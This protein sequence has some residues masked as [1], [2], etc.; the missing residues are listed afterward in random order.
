L[1]FK[2]CRSTHME[3]NKFGSAFFLFFCDFIRFS[4]IWSKHTKGEESIYE[5]VPRKFWIYTEIPS[6]FTARP[7]GIR[8]LTRVPSTT[9]ASSPAA[10]GGRRWATCGT[11]MRLSSPGVDSWRRRDRRGLRRVVSARSQWSSR[12]GSKSNGTRDR[13]RQHTSG[14]ALGVLWKRLGSLV[15]TGSEQKRE[16]TEAVT[17]ENDDALHA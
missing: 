9:E 7:S 10:R 8:T 1:L 13:A 3:T 2:S 15:G 6:V 14:E 16:L 17:M 4:K 5:E 12:C 11:S